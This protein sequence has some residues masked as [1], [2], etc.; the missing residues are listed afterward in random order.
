MEL[1]QKILL[2]TW[3]NL[4]E[5]AP[6]LLLG[7]F[8][9]GLLSVFISPETVE[10]QL[11]G[12]GLWPVVKAAL[13]GIPLPLCSCGVIPV[14][15]SL[16]RHGASRG[17]TTSFLISTPQ[18]GVDSILVT[19]S[20]LGPVFAVFRPLAALISGLAGGAA[21]SA[22]DDREAEEDLGEQ[23]ASCGSSCCGTENPRR[24]LLPRAMHYGFVTLPEDIAKALVIG[25]LLAG[26]IAAL[27]PNDFFAGYLGSGFTAMLVMLVIG[28]P[29]YVCATGSVPIAAA[30]MVKGISPGAALVFL[31]TGPATNAAT[32][33]TIWKVLG[34]RTALLYLLTVC[35]TALA[36]G[37][38]LDFT[39]A[40]AIEL[41]HGSHGA[42][43]PPWFNQVCAL[44]LVGIL[45]FALRPRWLRKTITP[46]IQAMD[47]TKTI[48]LSITGMSCNHC[49]NSVTRALSETSGVKE[50][51]VDLAAGRAVVVGE[52]LDPQALCAKIGGLGYDAMPA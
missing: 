46:E 33:S 3:V 35:L 18:T 50:V 38:A 49:A 36:T 22:L 15:V 26:L 11:G 5:M 13:F 25:L 1:L 24:G 41:G 12:R 42:M 21:V 44:A 2:E 34:R 43:L 8:V 10:R 32:I 4:A 30:L 52:N 20:L 14:G 7:F 51:E 39:L 37:A 45:A 40:R 47:G 23:A 16:R 48:R 29:L 19:Y 9:A 6:Y 27:V 28:I 17:A 31:M